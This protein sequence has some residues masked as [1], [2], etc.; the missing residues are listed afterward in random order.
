MTAKKIVVLEAVQ[1][2]LSD[3]VGFYNSIAMGVGSYFRNCLIADIE[4]LIFLAGVHVKRFGYYRMLSKKFP[5]AVYYDIKEEIVIV[6]A[7][8]GLKR[9]PSFIR[10][11]LSK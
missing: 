8:L 3:G 4:S 9:N 1:Q 6:V 11:R 5:Y 2:D 7:I 10:Q